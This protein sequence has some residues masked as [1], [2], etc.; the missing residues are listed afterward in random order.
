MMIGTTNI[1][2]R[3][4]RLATEAT[5]LAVAS[6]AA[7]TNRVLSEGVAGRSGPGD[8]FMLLS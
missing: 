1:Q 3:L 7:P 4:P 2:K 5:T 8:W 6:Y